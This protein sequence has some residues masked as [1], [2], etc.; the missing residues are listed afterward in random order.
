M[1][2]LR[3]QGVGIVGSRVE[4][5][6]DRRRTRQ[7]ALGF[8]NTCFSREGIDVVGRNIENLIKLSQGFRETTKV[9]IGNRV[10][11]E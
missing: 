4:R 2:N 8:C 7:I 5:S 11:V 3:F 10:L 6:E 1:V 9:G